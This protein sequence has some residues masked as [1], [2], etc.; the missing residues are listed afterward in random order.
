MLPSEVR[1][2]SVSAVVSTAPEGAGCFA[3]PKSITFACPVC[4]SMT[5]VG[6]MSRWTIPL[7]RATFCKIKMSGKGLKNSSPLRGSPSCGHRVGMVGLVETLEGLAA[8]YNG[9]VFQ[10]LT[11]T[12]SPSPMGMMMLCKVLS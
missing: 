1:A 9:A 2:V 12:Q 6:L 5:L 3:N 11:A 7:P 4:V 10:S 8:G